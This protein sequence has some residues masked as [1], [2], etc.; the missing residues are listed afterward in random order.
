MKSTLFS[1]P[2]ST[3]Y[4]QNKPLSEIAG[5]SADVQSTG[6]LRHERRFRWLI[7]EERHRL[8][9]ESHAARHPRPKYDFFYG[10]YD[11]SSIVHYVPGRPR[12]VT[13]L[14]DPFERLLSNYY[15]HRSFKWSWIDA[16]SSVAMA[17]A[18]A[19]RSISDFLDCPSVNVRHLNDNHMVRQIC[20]MEGFDSR[21]EPVLDW[22][23]IYD[24]AVAHLHSL[25]HVG[26]V[27]CFPASVR[28]LCRT[29]GTDPDAADVPLLNSREQNALR[30]EHPNLYEP[31][32]ESVRLTDEDRET[33]EAFIRW[34]R[35]LYDYA[36][37][38]FWPA[39]ATGA[40]EP[41]P[42]PAPAKR[43]RRKAAAAAS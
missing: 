43:R 2:S 9:M 40:A 17:V 38:T 39:E 11:Y 36:R 37:R 19:S 27:E 1:D 31:V 26:F 3:T 7:G 25:A 13:F 22:P 41:P 28:A 20:G 29:L 42:A 30:P 16:E 33:M 12:I 15:Y 32:F 10:H 18:K 14:R 5:V 35:R 23:E 6:V 34:D 8:L 24:R 4:P 21:F